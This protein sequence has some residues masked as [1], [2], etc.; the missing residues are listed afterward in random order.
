MRGIHEGRKEEEVAT[1]SYNIVHVSCA[2]D[3]QAMLSSKKVISKKV[4]VNPF[5]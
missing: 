3:D 2:S 1:Y 4:S 5:Q